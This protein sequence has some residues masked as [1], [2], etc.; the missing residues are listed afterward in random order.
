M[1][2]CVFLPLSEALYWFRRGCT[3]FDQPHVWYRYF[4]TYFRNPQTSLPRRLYEIIVPHG[5]FQVM[6]LIQMWDIQTNRYI[7]PSI[8]KPP[9]Y[10]NP[11][12]RKP[13]PRGYTNPPI[14]KPTDTQIYI[15][16]DGYTPYRPSPL[17]CLARRRKRVHPHHFA[18][19]SSPSFMSNRHLCLPHFPLFRSTL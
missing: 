4:P 11:R 13:T 17:R 7:Y 8:R 12:I 18:K 6:R 10:T 9:G 5:I 14:R 19:N 16:R 15:S 1:G 2:F 3:H